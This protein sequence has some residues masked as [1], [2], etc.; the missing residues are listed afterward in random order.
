MIRAVG[1]LYP[2]I[3]RNGKWVIIN[4]IMKDRKYEV[5]IEFVD[6]KASRRS[7][8]EASVIRAATQE[9]RA[10]LGLANPAEKISE[11]K[12]DKE[13]Y[14]RLFLR[15]FVFLDRELEHKAEMKL[16]CEKMKSGR[17]G[18]LS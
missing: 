7:T 1:T 11:L 15:Y 9:H 10:A 2:G 17:D 5:E 12:K 18:R 3:A 6:K 13:R 14:Y 16:S 4:D 8:N